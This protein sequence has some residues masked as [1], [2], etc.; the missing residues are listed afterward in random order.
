MTAT[1]SPIFRKFLVMPV[2]DQI[3]NAKPFGTRGKNSMSDL[4]AKDAPDVKTE[5]L[6][7]PPAVLALAPPAAPVVITVA[8]PAIVRESSCACSCLIKCLR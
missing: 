7:V 4:K 2:E 5:P 1:Y 8:Q 6:N 3:A